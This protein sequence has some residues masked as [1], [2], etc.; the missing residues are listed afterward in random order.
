MNNEHT[1]GPWISCNNHIDDSR[2]VTLARSTRGFQELNPLDF[3]LMAAAPELLEALAFLLKECNQHIP[4]DCEC[5]KVMD[6]A[7][8]ARA[9]IA[10]ATGGDA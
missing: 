2:G 3:R 1:P 10:K 8:L 5:P 4:E 6:A 7:N 9:A